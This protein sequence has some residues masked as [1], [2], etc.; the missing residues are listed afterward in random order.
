VLRPDF[1]AP[2]RSRAHREQS[3]VTRSGGED[4]MMM[5]WF[6]DRAWRLTGHRA[7]VR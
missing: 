7:V 2:G 1:G 6:G 3:T 4:S 5:S